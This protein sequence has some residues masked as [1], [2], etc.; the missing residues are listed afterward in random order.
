MR[1][2]LIVDDDPASLAL[3][4]GVLEAEGYETRTAS[5]PVQALEIL[6]DAR[7]HPARHPAARP[8]QRARVR[9]QA[10]EQRRHAVDADRR[11]HRLRRAV[12]R[13]G[14]ARRRL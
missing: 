4:E 1:S 9:A 5:A 6:K 14:N 12:D 2:I 13:G 11:L 7:C 3:M 8:R 10:Q